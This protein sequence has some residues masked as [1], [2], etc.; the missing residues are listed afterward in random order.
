MAEAGTPIKDLLERHRELVDD[1]LARANAYVESKKD[2]TLNKTAIE[3]PL[4]EVQS[5]LFIL[6][7]LKKK[8]KVAEIAADN[9]I[10]TLEFRKE[11]RELMLEAKGS[12]VIKYYI[13]GEIGGYLGDQFVCITWFGQT[14]MNDLAKKHGSLEAATLAGYYTTEQWRLMLDKRTRETGRLCKLI[15]VIDAQGLSLSKATNRTMLQAM[16]NVSKCNEMHN[17]QLLS[18]I[19]IVHAPYIFHVL[20]NICRPFVSKNTIDKIKMCGKKLGDKDASPCPFVSRYVNGTANIP[21]CLGG[22]M[23]NAS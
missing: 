13:P 3:Y 17:P 4:D 21:R 14:D 1:V 10:A 7:A 22:T 5:L 16:G 15:S 23:E 19:I 9:L 8:T 12:T 2:V 6:S 11:H 18:K 20:L